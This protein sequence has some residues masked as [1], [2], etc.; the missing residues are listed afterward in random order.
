MKQQKHAFKASKYSS[1]AQTESPTYIE[2]H[3]FCH[4]HGLNA[5]KSLKDHLNEALD[6]M[7]S[8]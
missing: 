1:F 4:Y 8:Y 2:Q 3:S 7:T 6:Q 5:S